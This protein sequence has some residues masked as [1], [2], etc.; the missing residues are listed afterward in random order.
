MVV[1]TSTPPRP[2]QE[3]PAGEAGL[4][5]R[6]VERQPEAPQ[7]GFAGYGEPP[8]ADQPEDDWVPLRSSWQPSAQ[9]WKPLAETWE[10]ARSTTPPVI[11]PEPPRP[12]S[13][14][15]AA[16]ATLRL[17]PPH[18][19]GEPVIPPP[20]A[21][22]PSGNPTPPTP[23][24][25]LPAVWFNKAFDVFLVPLGPVGRWLQGRAGRGVLGAVGLLALAAAAALAAADGCGWTH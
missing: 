13:P 8:S 12:W 9:T 24:L 11:P 18:T 2:P 17:T 25:L 21:A 23:A 14:A 1:E 20:P 19:I 4:G 6:R 10:Q 22:V 15:P 16:S 7:E 5:S 3:E